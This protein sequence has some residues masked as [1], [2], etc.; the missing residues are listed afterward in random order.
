MTVPETQVRPAFADVQTIYSRAALPDPYPLYQRARQHGEVVA[1][2]EWNAAAVFGHDEASQVLRSPAALSGQQLGEEFGGG[3]TEDGQPGL[4]EALKLLAPMMLFHNGPS[5]ARLRGLVSAAFTPRVVAEQ[6]ELVRSLVRECL[7][8]VGEG[9]FDV[10]DK[11]AIPLPVGVITGMLGL[12]KADEQQFRDWTQSVAELLGGVDNS[13]EL[14]ARI[15]QDAREMRSYFRGLADDL[16][17]RPQPGLLSA[18]AAAEDEEGRLSSDEL[19]ANAVLLLAAGHETTSNLIGRGVL[20]LHRQAGAW[21]SLLELPEIGN[22]VADELLR[23]TSPVQFTGRTLGAPLELGGQVYPAGTRMLLMLAAANR[24]ARTFADPDRL[25]FSRPNAARH[26]AFASGPHYCL[27]ASL[28]R[29]ETRVVFGELSRYPQLRV[30]QQ[31]LHYRPNLTLRGLS[32]LTV[33][34][35]PR[36]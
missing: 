16:R 30:P 11:L 8:G 26:L 17:A 9:P 24:D 15:E 34:L 10:V 2:P 12:S 29:L 3:Q 25:D 13:P 35:G 28:A 19:L 20:E 1:L 27:G 6:E 21:N 18:L 36:A 23:F 5:H 4:P 22:A 7:A 33:E 14:M 31:P 32:R